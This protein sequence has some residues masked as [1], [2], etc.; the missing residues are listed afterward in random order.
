[1]CTF[2]NFLYGVCDQD[3]YIE[4]W[5]GRPTGGSKIK[6]WWERGLEDYWSYV[7]CSQAPY[8]EEQV[9]LNYPSYGSEVK[10]KHALLETAAEC[11][12]SQFLPKPKQKRSEEK[13]EKNK[14]KYLEKQQ[15]REKHK[16][17]GKTI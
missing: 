8:W 16:H 6:N 14:N 15:E 2:L 4:K 10:A 7:V 1:M 3:V 13:I 11:R 12:W 5:Q 17:L 9:A